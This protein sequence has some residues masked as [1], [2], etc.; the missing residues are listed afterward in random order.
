LF[1]INPPNKLKQLDSQIAAGPVKRKEHDMFFQLRFIHLILFAAVLCAFVVAQSKPA[2]ETIS[3]RTGEGTELAF[4]IS[5]DGRTIVFDLL[6]QLW[7]L[8][9]SGGKAHPITDA[10][11]DV[12]EDLDPSFSPDGKHI[13]FRGERDGR[14]GVWLLDIASGSVRQLTQL[15]NPDSYDGEAAWS[16]D[17]RSI[18]YVHMIPPDFAA[19]KPPRLALMTLDV[20]SG[21]TR[22]VAVSGIENPSI[23]DP[24]WIRGGKEI[25]FVVRKTPGDRRGR[26][27]SVP[28]AGGQATP[29][30]DESTVV[31][32]ATFSPD[33]SR[34]VYFAKDRDSRD[35]I[36][37]QEIGAN[38]PPVQLTAHAD[39]TTT[40]IRWIPNSNEL[41]YSADGRLWKIAATA[42]SVSN[43]IR[44]TA[45]LSITRQRRSLPQAR[46][47]EPG[48]EELARG[49][50]S[51]AISP[52]ARQIA[53]LALGKLWLIPTTAGP[54]RAIV[55]VPFGA[56][57]L[58]WA[59]DGN[60][61]AW[62]SGTADNEDLFAT[63]IRTGSTRSITALPGR[64]AYP[65]YS[66]D[67]RTIAFIHVK[68]NAGLLRTIAANGEKVTDPAKTSDLG[69]IGTNGTCP[70]QWSPESDG[71]LVCGGTRPNQLGLATFVPISGE[72]QTINKF[73]NAPIF[74]QWTPDGKL[75][76]LRH[77]RAWQAT[78]DR[79]GSVA[80]EPQ[81]LGSSA[82][83]YLSASRDGTLLF[84]SKGG[85]ALR[86]PDG[87]E[88]RIGWPI[89]YTPP[90][91]ATSL[92]HNVRIIDGTGT[93]ATT[94]R[95][96][97]IENGRIAR[98]G[99]PGKI[100]A[101]D[102]K[103]IDAS[104]RFVI[105][106]LI[107][108]HAHFYRPDLLPG[109]P[110]F[111]ITT[112]RDQGS[113]IAPLV[114]GADSVAAGVMQG[115]RVAYGGFQFYSDWSFDEDQGRG[116]EPE[117][118]SDHI[119]RSVDLLE[120]FGAQH[121]KTRTFRRWDINAKMITEAHRRGIRATGHCSHTLPLVAAGMDAKEH[122]GVCEERGN[123]HMYDDMIQLFK[124]ARIGVVPTISYVDFAVRLS[125]KP[126][127]LDADA[128]V[129]P[130]MPTKDNFEWM[131]TMTPA[132]RAE[133]IHD[134]RNAREGAM[135]LVQ[136]GLLVGAGTDIWQIPTG[137][138]MELEEM[139][140]AGMT[141]AQA[142]RAATVDA[143]RILGADQ[144]LGAIK[145]G[146]RADLVLL[147]ADPLSDI[148]NTRKIWNV[149]QDG[150]LIDRPAIVKAMKPR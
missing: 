11:K 111:G 76:F 100:A 52:D 42:G 37:L 6:G 61:V 138:H 118:D 60:E 127:L 102:A 48:R 126:E 28:A 137:V 45:S 130:F 19:R 85:L 122:I 143:A 73:P 1:A 101:G 81:A 23:A 33:G 5:P 63:D 18:A 144:Q 106:G 133:W 12:A 108:L 103:V 7:L 86:R 26:A 90:V 36:W 146:M 119:K 87:T 34:V 89:K 83:L 3:F 41:L 84:V 59:P 65:A 71:L 2:T 117:A 110:Y 123:T 128:E 10:V 54:P 69:K 17:G 145:V 93:P 74:L 105:P 149:I 125:E 22:E 88:H 142:L 98:I 13:V 67:G 95:D 75:V 56:G 120:A 8:R 15:S 27:W 68:D 39:L 77:D 32:A 104:N 40:R 113:S 124:A 140:L 141:P 114:A 49:F 64:E 55:D 35:E 38:K 16:P 94:A 66:P 20:G 96:I 91:A 43:E 44:F 150:R 136:S 97:L 79:K 132:Q 147:D 29:V 92:I 78:L 25:A 47:P 129:A 82:A 30:T 58:A 31:Q 107:D 46:F 121:I 131:T 4:D 134:V 139:V 115:P 53:M 135:R 99:L 57:M 72:R 9:A 148:T 70:P 112:V 109:W 80:S 50:N 21:A 14:T 116:I 62:S 24:V 51:L